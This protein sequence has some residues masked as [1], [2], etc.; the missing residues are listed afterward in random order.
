MN[1]SIPSRPRYLFIDALRGVAAVA[2]MFHH[3]LHS[4]VLEPALRTILP[5]LLQKVATYG[6]VGVEIFFV[7]SGFVIAHSLAKVEPNPAGIGQFILRRQLRLDPPYWTSLALI[8]LLAEAERI[9]PSLTRGPL[10]GPSVVLANALYLQGILQQPPISQVAWTLCLEIQF[11]LV[12]IAMLALGRVAVRGRW[13]FQR[14]PTVA[15]ICVS[16]LGLASL[17]W[18]LRPAV[19]IVWFGPHW[20]YFAVGALICWT[21]A[22]RMPRAVVRIFLAAMIAVTLWRHSP[23]LIAGCATAIAIYAAGILGRLSTWL[24]AKPF[25]WL[26]ARSYSLY[27]VHLPILSIAMR[28]GYKLTHGNPILALGWMFLAAGICL[29]SAHCFHRWIERPSMNFASAFGRGSRAI[30]RPSSE[31]PAPAMQPVV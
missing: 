6:A 19:G 2:V 5:T 8:V 17:L 27:L 14:L 26:G 16:G 22:D 23:E 9:L 20:C 31:A 24:A 30:K 4:T 18:N 28:G 25:Q 13:N 3:L 15:W 10:P 21:L 11:Y 29:A 7:I 1:A 12:F